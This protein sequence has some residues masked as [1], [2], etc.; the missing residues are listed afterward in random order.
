[1]TIRRLQH[2]FVIGLPKGDEVCGGREFNLD[3]LNF[4]ERGVTNNAPM[5]PVK[6]FST[7]LSWWPEARRTRG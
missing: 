7:T 5:A 2:A 1:L 4:M 3:S 6:C